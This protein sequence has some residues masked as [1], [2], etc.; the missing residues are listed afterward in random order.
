ME[1][2]YLEETDIINVV[3]E[4]ISEQIEDK[5]ECQS[6]IDLAEKIYEETRTN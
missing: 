5:E 1:K 3:K 6:T 2:G 4:M